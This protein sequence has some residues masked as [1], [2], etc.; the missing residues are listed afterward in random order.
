[1][2]GEGKEDVVKK[3][4][5]WELKFWSYVHAGDGEHCPVYTSCTAREA[6][7]LCPDDGKELLQLLLSDMQFKPKEYSPIRRL[8]YPG[9]IYQWVE[10]LAEE[11][12]E[13]LK[14]DCPPVPTELAFLSDEQS[15]V[16]IREIPLK[17]CAG[18]LW[19]WKGRWVI[20]LK[21]DDS[22]ARQRLTIFHEVFHIL[23]HSRATAAPAFK[24]RE[25]NRGAFNELV[26][27]SFGLFVLTPRQCVNIIWA[28]YNDLDKMAQIFAVP[29]SAMWLRLKLLG[30]I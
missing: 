29:E 14:A 30:L 13:T 16:E 24:K 7:G 6:G 9:L 25:Q 18:A 11:Y 8:D 5:E 4:P 26:A 21:S 20:Y 12:L 23:A 19:R 2:S 27:D 3:I 28:K 15:D 22:R 1:L 10:R 17:L